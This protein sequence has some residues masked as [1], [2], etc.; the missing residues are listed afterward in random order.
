[1]CYSRKEGD[2][3]AEG[4]TT[5]EANQRSMGWSRLDNGRICESLRWYDVVVRLA[6][7]L[8]ML[9]DCCIC[10]VLYLCCIKS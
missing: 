6:L 4:Y 2:D 1:M 8:Y 10:I 5:G 7:L 9:D 3:H